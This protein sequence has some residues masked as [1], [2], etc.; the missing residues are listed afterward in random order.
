MLNINNESD[1]YG[2][3]N[4]IQI[5]STYT[6]SIWHKCNRESKIT[7]TVFGEK[8][9][10]DT[11]STWQKY[12]KTITVTEIENPN[13]YITSSLNTPTY[14][15]EGFLSE[16]TMDSSWLPAPEDVNQ[17][18]DNVKSTIEQTE[19]SILLKV[20]SN[21]QQISSLIV[22]LD[23]IKTSVS[24][25]EK[26]AKSF[27]VQEAERIQA[28]VRNDIQGVE[29]SFDQ[30]AD[31]IELAVKNNIEKLESDF[32]QRA[33]SIELS[34]KQ[35]GT[36]P[37]SFRYLRDWLNGST[38]DSRNLWVNCIINQRTVEGDVNI[39]L[40]KDVAA[41]DQN[42]NSISVTNP[43]VFTNGEL[44]IYPGDTNMVA[45]AND[46]LPL[47]LSYVAIDAGKHC[48]EI[49]LGEIYTD[50]TT[51][52]IWHYY[53]DGRKFNHKIEVSSDGSSWFTIYDSEI[54][55]IY[56]EIASGKTY[57][58]DETNLYSS[59]SALTVD[60]NG[61]SGVV[62]GLESKAEM[63]LTEDNFRLGIGQNI[64]TQI[65]NLPTMQDINALKNDVVAETEEKM[66]LILEAS[67]E[68]I[69]TSITNALGD[70]LSSIEQNA[71]DW[72]ASFRRKFAEIGMDDYEG[73]YTNFIVSSEGAEVTSIDDN[74]IKFGTKMKLNGFEGYYG[75]EIVFKIDKDKVYTYRVYNRGGIDFAPVDATANELTAN[76][77]VK[78]IPKV[79]YDNNNNKRYVLCHIKSGGSS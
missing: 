34:V 66:N 30:R 59:L 27:T 47:E 20:E 42:G 9:T 38:V 65:D 43:E 64:Q 15:Y 73:I 79:Y 71:D 8:E 49:D 28:V 63:W 39:A 22:N 41:F 6:F 75:E 62:S 69:K 29:S 7:F 16:S 37:T 78:Y 18:I 68:S 36:T 35:K 56:S 60:L 21:S 26:R 10:V 55:G 54:N 31:S 53:H 72:T 77:G 44:L 50:L 23:S 70:R 14:F 4:V 45:I 5:A 61:I 76:G 40:D 48:L 19:R 67:S 11:N 13:I 46:E 57:I 58:L 32:N 52:N 3:M 2:L 17:D 25:A 12:I 1:A 51:I 24:D 33:D 74:N